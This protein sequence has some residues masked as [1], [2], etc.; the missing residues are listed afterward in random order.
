MA[1]DEK[2]YEEFEN[3]GSFKYCK[4]KKFSFSILI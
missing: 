1:F 3:N 4:E 2:E